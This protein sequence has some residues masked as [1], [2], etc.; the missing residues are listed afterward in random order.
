MHDSYVNFEKL[1]ILQIFLVALRHCMEAVTIE[2]HR[3]D[4]LL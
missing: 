4:R 2:I 1:Q 3:V